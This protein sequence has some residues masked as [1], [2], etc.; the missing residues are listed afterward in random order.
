MDSIREFKVTASN[1]KAEYGLA[2]GGVVEVVSKSG[3]NNLHGSGMLFYRNDSLTAL[4]AF[5]TTK[6]PVITLS[7]GRHTR[8]TH[9]EGQDALF[10]G[11]RADGR[12]AELHHEHARHLAAGRRHVPE[13]SETLE[14]HDQARSAVQSKS[15]GVLS[16][17]AGRRVSSNR[18]LRRTHRA[19]RRVRFRRAAEVGGRRA[20][21]AVQRQRD[22]RFPVPVRVSQYEISPPYTPNNLEVGVFSIL[23]NN[24][25]DRY[26]YPSVTVGGCQMSLG[27]ETRWQF[28]DDFV[29]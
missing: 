18:Q 9:R 19:E 26:T 10:R 23:L 7:V 5:Q 27:P 13:R 24:C 3:T 4:Q 20:H 22:Q 29:T 15:V 25:T 16:F 21:V 2:T 14:L 28:K 12:A 17:R 8:R 11:V 1:F 6:P